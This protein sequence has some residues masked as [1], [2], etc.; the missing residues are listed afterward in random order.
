MIV[1]LRKKRRRIDVL[2]QRRPDVQRKPECRR[3]Q[4]SKVTKKKNLCEN[5]FLVIAIIIIIVIIVIIIII[6]IISLT[7][8]LIFGAETLLGHDQQICSSLEEKLQL[9]AELTELTLNSPEAVPHRH[10]LVPPDSDSESP[11]QA[12]SL[13]SA[14]LR[15]GKWRWWHQYFVGHH[16]VDY[17]LIIS[18][19]L[20]F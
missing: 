8:N 14:A 5:F 18:C 20:L 11:P 6:T 1:V 12:S 2:R 9:Y 3:S 17:Y 13:L 19:D 15:E 16:N 10:L 4:S 7:P